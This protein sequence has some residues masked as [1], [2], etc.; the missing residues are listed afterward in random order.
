MLATHR[1]GAVLWSPEIQ[2]MK[3]QVRQFIRVYEGLMHLV[4][5]VLEKVS[6]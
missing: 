3:T 1:R 2:S 4:R 6:E 5:Q